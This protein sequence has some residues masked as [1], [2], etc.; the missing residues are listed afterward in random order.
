M[1]TPLKVV[2][3]IVAKPQARERLRSLLLLAVAKFRE[4][5]G[6]TAY[7]LLED[8]KSPGRFI[9]YE[10]WADEAA[11]ARHMTSPTMQALAPDIEDLVEGEIKQDFLSIPIDL[12]AAGQ[13]HASRWVRRCPGNPGRSARP[14]L[15][16]RAACAARG[17][18]PATSD[19]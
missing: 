12:Q 15:L 7:V 4:E 19:C 2:A 18:A 3:T 13:R 11:L 1:T 5:R 16:R 14:R 10:P 17:R 8:R 6:C 9:T